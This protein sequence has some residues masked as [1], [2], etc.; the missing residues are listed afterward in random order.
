MDNKNLFVHNI[1]AALQIITNHVKKT[2]FYGH[3]INILS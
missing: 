1:T 3:Y 2:L